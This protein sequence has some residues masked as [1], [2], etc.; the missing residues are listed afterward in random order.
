[1]N[2]NGALIN[3]IADTVGSI[4]STQYGYNPGVLDNQEV[5][6]PT[7]KI[8]ARLDWNLD[9]KN[10]LTLRHNMVN[11]ADDIYNPART[12]VLFGN[13]MYT[14]NSV[15][16]STVLQL[17]SALEE[18]MSNEL[19]VGYTTIRDS[20]EIAGEKFPTVIVSDS[21]ITGIGI[22]AGA[23]NFSLQNKLSTNVLEITDNFTYGM[24]NH[25]LTVGTQNEFFTFSNLFIRD[26]AGTCSF[27]SLNDLRNGNA[28]RLQYSFARPGYA[29]DWAA[30]F[31]TAQRGLYAQDEWDVADNFKVT[32]GLRAD[33]PMFFDE[34]S[35]NSTAET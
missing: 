8:F 18:S 34:A 16:N 33:M 20:R 5:T 9:D 1:Q 30:S 14:F 22:T 4:L 7:D 3:A 31:S 11:A 2:A 26:N 19:I 32:I 6:R 10:R 28:A 25:T 12:G 13:R 27:N 29:S 23:E 15:A 17:N 35:K 24:G 21:R